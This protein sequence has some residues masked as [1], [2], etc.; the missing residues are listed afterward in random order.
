MRKIAVVTGT[1]AEYGLLKNIIAK[2]ENDND[3]ELALVVTG[4]HLSEKYGKTVEEIINDGFKISKSVDILI[5][6]TDS[7]VRTAKEMAKALDKLT[8]VFDEVNPDLLLILGDRYE[9]FSAAAAAMAMNIP[10]AHISG[11]EIT[12]GAMDEQI[13]HSITKMAHIHFPGAKVY[14]DNIKAMGEESWRVFNVGD[15][16]IE[17]IKLT[18][19]MSQEEL[20]KQLG[21][22]VDEDTILI[23]YHPVTLEIN[24]VGEQISNLIEALSQVDKKMIITYPN[25]DNGGDII[26]EAIEAF[27]DK[28]PDKVF[29]HKNLGSLRYLSVMNLCGAIVG[30]SSSALVEAPFMKKPVVN[31]GNRQKGRLKANNIIDTTYDSNEILRAIDQCFSNEFIR[32]VKDTRSLYGE[33]NTSDEIVTILKTI[34]LGENLIKKKLR[35]S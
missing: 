16:G 32:V 9:V 23:T 24:Q 20:E 34:E 3:L 12:E 4:T 5:E 28:Y 10:I 33:G 30:N 15:P 11:G 21:V 17:N 6:D 26:I 25:A 29:L 31:I 1:R 8:D 2:I 22:C 7:K 14:A 18:K 27:K 35:W 13:R 19:L